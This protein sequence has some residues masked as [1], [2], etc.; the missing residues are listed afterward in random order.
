MRLSRMAVVRKSSATCALRSSSRA[1]WLKWEVAKGSMTESPAGAGISWACRAGPLSH[2]PLRRAQ[3]RAGRTTRGKTGFF[4]AP[5]SIMAR[6]ASRTLQACAYKRPV[7]SARPACWKPSMQIA[8][9]PSRGA[10][11]ES[12]MNRALSPRA[13]GAAPTLRSAPARR[14]P[15]PLLLLALLRDERHRRRVH[16]VAQAGR[17]GAVVEDMA[18]M[19][20]AARARHLVAHHAET[21]VDGGLH[22]GLRDRGPEAR[23]AGSGFELG[24][25][26]EQLE[27]AARALVDASG[28][29]VPVGACEGR[30]GALVA[31]DA[32]L[33][34]R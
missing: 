16:A 7:H 11:F 2:A 8:V 9:N 15:R 6:S 34:G 24:G 14:A 18:E 22:M 31:Q 32:V 3:T 17:R 28:M 12:E 29:V 19:S 20:A 1:L 23:P 4:P 13:R 26:V 27:P 5:L 25:G 33:L 10:T 30:L 21:A